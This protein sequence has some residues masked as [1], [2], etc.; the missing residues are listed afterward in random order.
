MIKESQAFDAVMTAPF[1]AVGIRTTSDALTAIQYLP[2]SVRAVAPKNAL[3][4][5]AVRQ[6]ER[7]FIDPEFRFD[8]PLLIGGT[9]YQRRVWDALCS[10]RVGESMT[11]GS[12]ARQ[13]HSS[14]R[15]VGQACGANRLP[16]VIPC[17]RVVG[18]NDI[19]GFAHHTDG[20][21]I[22]TKQWLL[23]HEAPARKNDLLTPARGHSVSV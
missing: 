4:G 17:H 23:A 7:Y 12:M 18:A 15:A 14:P 22:S 5:R 3:A 6:I 16:I 13:L 8:L 21:L 19:G 20:Y 2:K 9:A 11:Y 1:G 10:M